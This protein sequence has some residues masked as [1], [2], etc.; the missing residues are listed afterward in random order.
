MLST[1]S[2]RCYWNRSYL[3][4]PYNVGKTTL[5]K[6]LV[7]DP[8]SEERRSTDGIWIYLGRAGM[9]ID[10]R[11]WIFLPQGTTLN[12][13]VLSMLMSFGEQDGQKEEEEQHLDVH[14]QI[15]GETNNG[16]TA[17]CNSGQYKMKVV[18]IDLWDF[19]GQKVYYMTHQLFISSRGIFIIIFN[20]SKNINKE[21]SDLSYLPGQK[22]KKTTAV[23]LI[24]WVNSILT[25]C[26]TSKEGFPKIL[27]VATHKDLINKAK[28]IKHKTKLTA[29]IEELFKDH[30]GRK[31]LEIDQLFFVNAR[32]KDDPEIDQLRKTIV[33]V[34][35]SHPRWGELM[36]TVC[37][38][39]D[40]QLMQRAEEGMK[41]MS[42]NEIEK[43]N[44]AN[45]V[46]V[47]TQSQLNTFLKIQHALGKYIYFNEGP[48]NKY[49]VIDPTYLVEVLRS[50]VTEEE[51]WPKTEDIRKIYVSL[52]DK[53]ILTKADLLKLWKQKEYRSLEGYKDY[54]IKMLIHLD[55]LI[56][57]RS[58]FL[59]EIQVPENE[60]FYLVPC[61]IKQPAKRPNI[62]VDSSIY[63]AYAFNEEVIPPAF[64]YRFLGSFMSM[65]K[66]KS[67]FTD[68]AIVVVDKCHELLLYADGKRLVLELLHKTNKTGIIATVASTV[69]ECLTRS[70]IEIS[71]FYWSAT[72]STASP[73]P[74]SSSM[75]TIPEFSC[76]IHEIKTRKQQR[77]IPYTI[78]FGVKC[79]SGL[80]FFQ[81]N[82]TTEN[83]NYRWKCPVHKKQHDT[84]D[85]RLWFAEK[86]LHF[87]NENFGLVCS[88]TCPGLGE[89]EI[90]QCPSD[91][92]IG[93]LVAGLKLEVVK[94][95]FVHLDMPMDKWEDIEHNY[96]CSTD[97]KMF[98]LW[99]WKQKA[100]K[101]TFGALKYAL[102]KV[103][104]DFHKLC[105]VFREVEIPSCNIPAE[106]LTNIPNESILENLS[107]S[108]GNDNMQLGLELGFKG[109]ELQDIAFQHK[110]RLM[111]QTREIFRRWS[112]RRQPLSVIAKAFIRIDKFGVF[113]RCCSNLF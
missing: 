25:Y 34:A 51:F 43:I 108:I 17:E 33:E 92:Q 16:V 113:T 2:Y 96:P 15:Y 64:M 54:M 58:S 111:E 20:G 28:V 101:A 84:S 32:D 110:T 40:L 23:Y 112:K 69:Q 14:D 37:V 35:F 93:R 106:A 70:I 88:K 38:P 83:Q 50:V 91:Q 76:V 46:M 49:A 41:I 7:D 94:E 27:F 30:T 90:E 29:S 77:I 85:L 98:A 44:A 61:M 87:A 102:S 109:A 73:N 66:I 78:E 42:V 24:H 72:N 104:Q 53:G 22:G 8:I 13:S 45:G 18:P 9:D 80:C 56:E 21:M 67:M 11:K 57:P 81:H 95:L 55:I 62:K 68:S 105:E 86:G 36:P 60:I 59:S 63:L 89:L 79:A 74:E 71:K 48:L 52:R 3:V 99:E 65:W 1:A 19:G 97:L 4:G 82:L 39:L 5:A 31:H 6:N 26:K 75:K 47:L 10:D 100:E 12:A 107:N 103:N